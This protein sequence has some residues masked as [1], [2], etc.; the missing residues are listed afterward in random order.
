MVAV[1]TR[2]FRS[3]LV[4]GFVAMVLV[5]SLSPLAA[6]AIRQSVV[7]Q[8]IRK[9]SAQVQ[10]LLSPSFAQEE[11][12]AGLRPDTR[13]LMDEL[14]SDPR[15]HN[16]L[17]VRLWS[18]DGTLLYSNDTNDDGKYG[19]PYSVDT[20]YLSVEGYLRYLVFRERNEWA[21]SAMQPESPSPLPT[22]AGAL[23]ADEAGFGVAR[24]FM[25]VNLQG[26]AAPAGA[27]EVFYDFR[28]LER[29]LARTQRAVW[30]TIPGGILA[31]YCAM[32]VVVQR[33]PDVLFRRREDSRPAHPGVFRTLARVVDA[34]DAETA[35][36]SGRV[37]LHAVA[38]ARRLKLPAEAIAELK[39][40]AAL[41]DIGKISVPD[42]VL[43]KPG[44]LTSEEWEVVR[45]H[46]AVGSRILQTAPLS[47]TI[48]QAVRHVHE[49]WDG[50]GYPDRLEGEQIP[51]F[52]RILAVADAF[53]AMTSDRPYR[54][55]LSPEDALAELAREQGIQFDPHLVD[56]FC[57]W[58]KSRRRIA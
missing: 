14:S 57:E 19:R 4:G 50:T 21:M 46:A 43:T 41:H 29:K 1:R 20:M 27:L 51:L 9:V 58:A 23:I 8:E 2:T 32:L 11:F 15:N 13:E 22:V 35:D 40:A 6:A 7:D 24:L 48:K 3:A 45:Q 33:T 16:V 12:Q 56:V 38:M 10:R 42:A 17:R 37:A 54:R 18:R 31:L 44:P 53:E 36:H 26:S 28:P 47:D 39:I 55:A 34:R 49:R 30:T 5:A 52:A 25:P